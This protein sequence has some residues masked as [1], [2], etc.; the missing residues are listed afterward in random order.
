M[1]FSD[2]RERDVWRMRAIL[3]VLLFT[4]WLV[5]GKPYDFDGKLPPAC[6]WAA[7]NLVASLCV[8]VSDL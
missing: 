6:I 8:S 2:T 3:A 7:E 1:I 4:P 5:T